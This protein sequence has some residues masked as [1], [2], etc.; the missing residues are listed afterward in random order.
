MTGPYPLALLD[1]AG[2]NWP[3]LFR[4]FEEMDKEQ[5]GCITRTWVLKEQ[6]IPKTELLLNALVDDDG[7][8]DWKR[9]RG[10]GRLC[11]QRT[12]LV[13]FDRSCPYADP[14][15]LETQWVLDTSSA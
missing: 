11:I 5:G 9:E 14:C 15:T 10:G 8:K 1:R 13:L 12:T 3:A 2:R 7:A 6:Q 4:F